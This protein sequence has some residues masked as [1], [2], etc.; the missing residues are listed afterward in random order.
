MKTL[1]AK[2]L[3]EGWRTWRIIVLGIVLAVA[4]LASPVLAYYMPQLFR[5]IPDLPAGLAEVIPQ[6]AMVDAVAQYVKNV[7]QF[8]LLLLVVL[9]A[10]VIAAEKERGTA[11]MLFV[12]P[13]SRTN[14]VLAKWLVWAGALLVSVVVSGVLAF[15]YT[16]FL[17]DLPPTAA[18]LA[19]NGLLLLS[20]LPYLSL[21]LLGSV[22]ARTQGA[23]YGYATIAMFLL[24][25]LGGLPRIGDFTPAYLP[26]WGTALMFEQ[27]ASGVPALIISLALTAGALVAACVLL[28]RQEL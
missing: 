2:E 11:A 20:F 23:A 3:R 26:T 1:L 25:I 16:A 18:F 19:L 17:F 28:E 5:L 6:P 10:G 22:I 24:I 4:G 9:T 14:A 13:V 15:A 8:G 27:P 7:S 21:S 12:R